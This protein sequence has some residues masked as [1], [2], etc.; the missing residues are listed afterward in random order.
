MFGQPWH[1]LK[2]GICWFL[3]ACIV[4]RA[5][6]SRSWYRNQIWPDESY[7]QGLVSVSLLWA[8]HSGQWGHSTILCWG[9]RSGRSLLAAAVAERTHQSATIRDGCIGLCPRDPFLALA[10]Q[11]CQQLTMGGWWEWAENSRS[12]HRDDKVTTHLK[13]VPFKISHCKKSHFSGSVFGVN[14]LWLLR[15]PPSTQAG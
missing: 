10:A 4:G 8:H 9:A 12:G 1:R 11:P 3:G 15:F 14:F 13:I 2:T 6:P 5:G 7:R